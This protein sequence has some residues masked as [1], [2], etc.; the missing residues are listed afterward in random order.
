MLACVCA[1]LIP[2]E[3]APNWMMGA[4]SAPVSQLKSFFQIPRSV[5]PVEC[6][7]I[8]GKSAANMVYGVTSENSVERCVADAAGADSF[9]LLQIIPRLH[10]LDA[11]IH[12]QPGL[13]DR[14]IGA[15]QR[16]GGCLGCSFRR[17]AGAE[18]IAWSRSRHRV[19]AERFRVVCGQHV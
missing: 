7:C 10:M 14:C 19:A 17:S 13:C 2:D 12:P 18:G 1:V 6:S 4:G 9:L 15:A 5:Q 16:S 11:G 3:L 8:L